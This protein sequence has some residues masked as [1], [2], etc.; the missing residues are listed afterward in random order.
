MNTAANTKEPPGTRNDSPA[1]S[2]RTAG[3]LSSRYLDFVI[4]AAL[5]GIN[6]AC[7]YRTISGFFLADDF[8][9]VAYLYKVFNGHPE[10][11]AQN[12]ITNWMQAEGTQFYRPF[13]SL[14]LALDYLLYGVNAT[15]YHITNLVYQTLSSLFLFLAARRLFPNTKRADA[16]ILAF[17]TAAFFA[18]NPLH[19]E[20]VSWI[21]ARVDSVAAT[22]YLASLYFFLCFAQSDNSRLKRAHLAV[23]LGTFALSL[24][25]KEMA[26]TL[27]PTLVL[28][29]LL[30][31][32]TEGGLLARVKRAAALT[33]PFWLMLFAYLGWR[34]LVLG[35][36]S[37]GYA[38]SIG[39]GL[40][41]SLAKRWLYD[42]SFSRVIFPFND[43][44]FSPSDRLRKQLKLLYQ[45]AG[46]LFIARI[47]IILLQRTAIQLLA[48]LGFA[49][50]WFVLAMVPTYQVWNLTQSLQGSRFIYLGTAPL[51][52]LLA[53]LIFPSV[54]APAR[55][56]AAG[57]EHWSEGRLASVLR[58]AS[59][60]LMGCLL[61]V[62][63][64]ITT[65]NNS[66]WY[67][68]GK[69]VKLLKER[70]VEALDKMPAGQNLILLNVP[71]R[72]C[73]AHMLYNAATM[74]VLLSPPMCKQDYNQRVFTFE[75]MT[76]GDSDLICTSRLKRLLQDKSRSFK[77]VAWNEKTYELVPL[78]PATDESALHPKLSG[79]PVNLAQ[80]EQMLVSPMLNL[81]PLSIDFVD[82]KTSVTPEKNGSDA[83]G[84]LELWW[85]TEQKPEFA[86]QRRLAR[87]LKDGASSYRF[88][89]SQH[90]SWLMSN[91]IR[92]IAVSTTGAP[93]TVR[94]DA[95]DFGNGRSEIPMLA[96]ATSARNA[97][98]RQMLEDNMGVCRPGKIIGPFNYSA[99]NI[100]GA[101]HV[102]FEI[103]KPDSWFE[104]YSGELR[105]KQK[106]REALASGELPGLA[107]ADYAIATDKIVQPGFYEL[108]IV[109]LGA[110]GS[111][112]GY[113][114]EPLNFQIN[115]EDLK[116][117][118]Q[119]P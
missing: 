53:L 70:L 59:V 37:G 48:R 65:K 12:F 68:A 13:I 52:L 71:Q 25:S 84:Y 56:A 67:Y 104:H 78:E 57:K 38:G 2:C 7:F 46:A 89:V 96:P 99:A 114:S 45:L 94:I 9:H 18:A 40:S 110:D 90:K 24:I 4:F 75:P 80:S 23:G 54:H 107:A 15:G 74:G 108:R 16:T 11:L 117:P 77:V 60:A 64:T 101:R 82:V 30:C 8:V 72:Y 81:K 91:T 119:K 93:Y 112:A 86:A 55:L 62:Y 21:I 73:G 39:E 36:F 92:Q 58:M 69:G 10:L 27:P 113:C 44:L 26:I 33:W 85:T 41:N 22:F 66:A 17:F 95:V 76:Y 14:T 20:V 106:S 87:K 63:I 51:C 19:P 34:T 100:K 79:L 3:L 5:I 118:H 98:G 97:D 50:G 1:Q 102:I 49:L 42:N 32:Q 103:S 35:T 6:L 28:W 88:D 61:A 29:S 47:L 31:E 111:V 43:E 116:N 83:D 115:A 105:D 109:A